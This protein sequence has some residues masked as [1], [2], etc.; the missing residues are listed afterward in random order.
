VNENSQDLQQMM[1][2]E[3][4]VEDGIEAKCPDC[5]INT[6]STRQYV[7]EKSC[8]ILHI[9]LKRFKWDKKTN[10]SIKLS[11]KIKIP[12]HLNVMTGN[13]LLLSA[14]LHSGNLANR[15]HYLTIG[16][17][18]GDCN[19]AW[20]KT[21]LDPINGT[22]HGRWLYCNDHTRRIL[23]VNDLKKYLCQAQ[24]S[25]GQIQMSVYQVIYVKMDTINTVNTVIPIPNYPR[26]G[27]ITNI[28]QDYNMPDIGQI[29]LDINKNSTTTT[30]IDKS[31]K[32]TPPPPPSFYGNAN[33]EKFNNNMICN[34]N[35]DQNTDDEEDND[36]IDMILNNNNIDNN[37]NT[38]I[39]LN[40]QTTTI[41]Y[42]S[43]HNDNDNN[44]DNI[45]RM[46]EN[47]ISEDDYE[48]VPPLKVII[49][50]DQGLN[51]PNLGLKF[52]SDN[53]AD[54]DNDDDDDKDV[55]IDVDDD[56]L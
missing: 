18:I 48:H 27:Q 14:I 5:G 4:K 49:D 15:G 13:Y 52:Y 35:W 37:N 34:M 42:T 25:S 12:F 56:E 51:L 1:N 50:D 20:N 23:N 7:M 36:D 6:L 17:D 41:T 28:N 33:E 45:N 46:S 21:Q 32:P 47:E 54:E 11:N 2:D 53:D 26:L 24:N 43:T 3:F 16:R 22:A 30:T 39:E 44:A 19:T 29:N 40:N 8:K 31:K 38:D 9:C 55:D 10:K